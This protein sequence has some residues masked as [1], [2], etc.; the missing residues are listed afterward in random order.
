VPTQVVAANASQSKQSQSISW[1][2]RF[3]VRAECDSNKSYPKIP[4]PV[5][6][7]RFSCDSPPEFWF[8]KFVRYS[9]LSSP[10]MI[11]PGMFSELENF[12]QEGWLADVPSTCTSIPPGAPIVSILEAGRS[13][14]ELVRRC[15]EDRDRLDAWIAAAK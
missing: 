3:T 6:P 7:K 9:P 4:L 1:P 2:Q 15:E 10:L 5:L 12:W 14:S 8:G 11:S 13:E